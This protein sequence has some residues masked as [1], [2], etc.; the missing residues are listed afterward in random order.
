MGGPKVGRVAV[1]CKRVVQGVQ[2]V[3]PNANLLLAK[4]GIIQ[5]R[6]S[7]L[8]VRPFKNFGPPRII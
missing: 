1:S 3:H 7:A 6:G 2:P 5:D 4:D 8:P